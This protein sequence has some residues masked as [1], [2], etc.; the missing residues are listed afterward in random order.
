ML[1]NYCSDWKELDLNAASFSQHCKDRINF[2]LLLL[3]LNQKMTDNKEKSTDVCGLCKK[4]LPENLSSFGF[5]KK[6]CVIC[7]KEC[8]LHIKCATKVYNLKQQS[9]AKETTRISVNDFES[10]DLKFHCADCCQDHCIICKKV[11][12]ASK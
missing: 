8:S 3:L 10:F 4:S 6:F 5:H 11:H 7:N 12:N 2:T 9:H 1:P